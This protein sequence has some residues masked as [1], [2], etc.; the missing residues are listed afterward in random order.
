MSK[1]LGTSLDPSDV[2]AKFGADPLRLYLVKEISYGGD[3]DFTW[4]RYEERYNVDLANNLGNLVSRLAAMAEKYRASRL[5]AS[6][7]GGRLAQVADAAVTRYRTS[8]GAYAL[9]EATASAFQI[10]DATNEFIAEKAPWALAKDPANAS[11][12]DEVLFE[13]AEAIRIGAVLLTPVMPSSCAEILRRVGEKTGSVDLR[14]DRDSRWRADGA[15]DI[16][17]GAALWPRAEAP[18]S[19]VEVQSDKAGAGSRSPKREGSQT[20]AQ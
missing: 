9:H 6:G 15:R 17:K 13:V 2:A 16:V 18:G 3:G 12:L 1:S 4:E 7:S 8:M 19:A 10:V 20:R 11:R 5:G 14:L